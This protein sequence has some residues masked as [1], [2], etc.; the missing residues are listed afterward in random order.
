MT[1]LFHRLPLLRVYPALAQ[2]REQVREVREQ[3]R[4]AEARLRQAHE[5]LEQVRAKNEALKTE[6]HET[7]TSRRAL[8]AEKAR[9]ELALDG[10]TERLQRQE[11]ALQTLSGSDL[12]LLTN[13]AADPVRLA[14]IVYDHTS[15]YRNADPFPHIVVDEL[16]VPEILDR[17]LA[18]FDAM[19]RGRWHHAD[20]SLERKWSN[21]DSRQFGPF[22]AALFAQLNGGPFITFLE[23]LT[24]IRGLVPDPHL[25]G[26]GLHEI[27]ADGLLGVHADFNVQ[28]RLKLYRRLNL[29]IY[30]NK[31]WDEGW[32]GALELWDRKGRGCVRAI[33][34][35]F[36]RA[37]LFDTSNYSYHG[38]PH[39]LTCPPDRSRKSVALYYY[40]QEC[41]A[42]ED[43]K[44]HTTIFLG[45]DAG[46]GSGLTI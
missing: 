42:E 27:R 24:G 17:V 14:Q 40:S 34:P 41:P 11:F 30:L 12:H 18:E 6:L 1:R 46:P 4:Q 8:A 29:L 13:P 20:E 32:G 25:R 45:R 39:P 33:P 5:H 3:L 28:K 16:I 15:S 10:A 23:E 35:L 9:L 31:D 36:N 38:H 37:V 2:A 22:T 26:G 21:E 7:D 19:D 43:P 44:P